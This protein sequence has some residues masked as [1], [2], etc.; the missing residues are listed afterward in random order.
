MLDTPPQSERRHGHEP[1]RA[2]LNERSR[3]PGE[4]SSDP[5]RRSANNRGASCAYPYV[6]D[7]RRVRA[8]RV[9]GHARPRSACGRLRLTRLMALTAMDTEEEVPG[10][11]AALR[12]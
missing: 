2:R 5:R 3:V 11:L 6:R 1:A 8:F 9:S 10:A 7:R 12:R 4:A